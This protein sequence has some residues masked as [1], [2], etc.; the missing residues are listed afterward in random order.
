MSDLRRRRESLGLSRE[1]VVER[2]RIPLRYLVALEDGPDAELQKGPFLASYRRQYENFLRL[3]DLEAARPAGEPSNLIRVDERDEAPPAPPA[4]PVPVPRL[5]LSGFL[6]TLALALLFQIGDTLLHRDPEVAPEAP[7]A[8]AATTMVEP[9]VLPAGVAAPTEGTTP[10]VAEASPPAP[11]APPPLPAVNEDGLAVQAVEVRAIEPT[12]VTVRADGETKFSGL[13]EP[14]PA[15]SFQGYRRLEVD[16]SDL[17][18]IT[19]RHNGVRVEPLGNLSSGRRL[20]FL[21]E[22]E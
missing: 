9:M 8:M 1:D 6:A 19:L 2:A 11:V 7:A 15:R 13:L 5:V 22:S 10:L 14:G 18:R 12:R 16:A 3:D 20:V 17:T 4:A 21:Q